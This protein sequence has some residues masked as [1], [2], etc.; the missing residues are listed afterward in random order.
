MNQ[1]YYDHIRQIHQKQFEIS[2]TQMELE[3]ASQEKSTLRQRSLLYL[4]DA[5]LSLG[6]RVRPV[7][8]RE[9]IQGGQAQDGKLEIKAEGC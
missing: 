9:Q 3:N 2:I 4:S 7:E 8:F 6:Q 5:L 1:D